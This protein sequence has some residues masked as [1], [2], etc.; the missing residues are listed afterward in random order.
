MTIT[1]N[2]QSINQKL[3]QLRNLLVTKLHNCYVEKETTNS[4][5]ELIEAVNDIKA[6]EVIN[7]NNNRP[8]NMPAIDDTNL[9]IFNITLYE[10]I[11]YYMKLL[12]YFLVLKGVPR[13]EVNAQTDLKGLIELI[14]MIDVIKP[15]FLT[16]GQVDEIQYFGTNIQVPYTLKDIDGL[17]IEEGDITIRDSTGTVYDSIEVGESIVIT[18]LDISPKINDEYQYETFTIIYNGTD[19]YT[20]SAP[21]SFRVKILPAQIRL[22]LHIANMSSTSRYYNSATTG[23]ENDEWTIAIT[24]LNHQNQPLAEVPFNLSI[25]DKLVLDDEETNSN[26]SYVLNHQIIDEVGNH[27]INCETIYPDTDKMSNVSLNYT[28]HIKYNILKQTTKTYTDYTGKSQGYQYSVELIDEETGQK[29]NQYDGQ[30]IKIFL[31]E[32]YSN[33]TQNGDQIG[34]STIRD[35]TVTYTF[36]TLSVGNKILTWLF[37]YDNFSVHTTT[38]LHI[39]SNFIFPSKQSYFLNSTPTIIYA[40]E[41]IRQADNTITGTI[42][43]TTF[44]DT[45]TENITLTTNANGE[46]DTI[47]NYKDV[48][49]YNLT[50]NSSNGLNETCTWEYELKKPF[51]VETVNYDK[52]EL[53]QYKI[54]IY[55]IDNTTEYQINNSAKGPLSIS[56]IF[57]V[58]FGYDVSLSRVTTY[59][60]ENGDIQEYTYLTYILTINKT[61]QSVGNNTIIFECNGY[62]E[63][64]TFKF[65]NQIFTL[66]THSV[67]LG[68]DTMQ[69][70][71]N[72]DTVTSIE[73]DSPYIHIGDI[74]YENNIF[75]IDAIFTK[76]GTISFD[77]TDDSLTTETLSIEV[78][79]INLESYIDALVYVPYPDDSNT[80]DNQIAYIDLDKIAVL[81]SIDKTLYSDLPI[82]Y[83]IKQGNNQLHT[84]SFTYKIDETE[85]DF[86]LTV[87]DLMPG[88]YQLEFIFTGDINYYAFDKIVDFE[89]LKATPTH[90]ITSQYTN[91]KN[92]NFFIFNPKFTEEE[93]ARVIERGQNAIN[94]QNNGI[95]TTI[96][97]FLEDGWYNTGLWECDF[98]MKTSGT[99]RYTGVG[100]LISLSPKLPSE[101]EQLIGGWEG[102]VA[103]NPPGHFI[104][105]NDDNLTLA[106]NGYATN[107]NNWVH[108]NMKKT[109]P[110]TLTITKT[111]DVGHNGSVT[112][113]WQELS[114]YEK[115]TFGTWN[116]PYQNS[117]IGKWMIKDFIVRGVY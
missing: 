108:I 114:N 72:D 74:T 59:T 37:E 12:G 79:K 111:G 50:L 20:E 100:F 38:N 6:V 2:C 28:V 102:P 39:L 31:Y 5:T 91:F 95:W 96:H 67:T 89:V 88:Q 56:G 46:L 57:F 101:F 107:V 17:N 43:Y 62:Q 11:R 32:E 22:I 76:A 71:C 112:Y 4:F 13:Y 73:I 10:R 21:Q 63:S 93:P 115:L 51:D 105:D 34:T 16:L 116:N 42:Q 26:G 97:C 65:I 49:L 109:S 94:T 78:N 58:P 27:I 81:F 68:N 30:K 24:T 90:E 106:N 84:Q 110:T 113:E 77:A 3:N 60:D 48:G 69:I 103:T 1:S 61:E 70:K 33:N 35:G 87:P 55:D 99:L 80:D 98:D 117:V 54:T 64:L 85:N 40:P 53:I 86:T 92:H 52:K 29:T 7:K 19:K 41:G 23:Y 75:V 104:R 15:S 44:E 83:K 25:D 8:T 47:I 9:S 82:T 66:L 36:N 14:D 45:I 18:P